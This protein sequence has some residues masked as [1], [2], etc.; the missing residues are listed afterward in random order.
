MTDTLVEYESVVEWVSSNEAYH[1]N[2]KKKYRVLKLVRAN[3]GFHDLPEF[4]LQSKKGADQWCFVENKKEKVL[5]FIGER[6]ARGE[7][8]LEK[9]L[10]DSPE[11]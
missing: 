8:K 6:V 11:G 5:Q 1:L 9:R 7:I 3:I 4:V 2:H 10:F